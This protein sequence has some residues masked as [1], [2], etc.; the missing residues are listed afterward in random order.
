MALAKYYRA[1]LDEAGVGGDFY[2]VF[3]IDNGCTALVVGDLSGKGLAAATQVATVR[4]MLRYALYRSRTLA[5]GLRSLNSLMAEQEMLTGFVT[6]FIGAYD[7]A[8]D[9]LTYV[10]CGQEPALVRRAAGGPVERLP[11]TGPVLGSFAGAAFEERTVALGPGDAVAIFTDGLTE[12]G[13]SRR[14]MLDIEGVA[15]VL[16]RSV[17]PAEA[18]S[19]EAVAEHLARGLIG[20]VDAAARGGVVRDD[21]CLLVGV[22]E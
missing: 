21:M 19:A 22:V 1:A 7:G 4:N 9:T 12:V 14:E 18:G 8:A 11:P 6:L 5:G 3:P 10:N 13:R 20:G 16:A 2:D 17:I 15:D